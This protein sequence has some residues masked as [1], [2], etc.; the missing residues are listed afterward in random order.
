MAWLRL[1]VGWTGLLGLGVL[2]LP[3]LFALVVRFRRAR[4]RPQSPPGDRRPRLV[5]LVPAHNEELLIR[6][7]VRSLLDQDYPADRRRVVVIADNCSDETAAIARAAGAEVLERTDLEFRGKPRA[8]AWAIDQ[9]GLDGAD[10]FI[11]IDADSEVAADYA[12]R[13]A[14]VGD[15][16]QGAIQTYFGISN[17]Y[18][19]W[20]TRLAGVL[21][22][23]RYESQFPAKRRA[24]LNVPLT[25]NGMVLGA[26]LLRRRPWSAFSVTEDWELYAEYTA[27]GVRV[28]YLREARLISQEARSTDQ[29]ASQ[30]QRW[31]AGR[32]EVWR[33]WGRAIRTSTHISRFQKLDTLLE[34][35]MPS[36][37]LHIALVAMCG[38]AA[39]L[40]G[41][42]PGLYLLGASLAGG[43]L[44][45]GV[46][47][48]ILRH[49]EPLATVR[50]LA[51][52]PGYALWR[53]GVGIGA[54]LSRRAR[55]EW[56]R[57][58]RHE[59]R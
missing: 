5:F 47:A 18:E 50:A 59:H 30:R 25:G 17:E 45:V 3:G 21:M 49:P 7:C 15:L 48:T 1:L 33:E 14:E 12:K 37:A 41:M 55:S 32:R 10:A 28:D 54:R 51:R 46:V 26:E 27:H 56:V 11:V 20:L 39:A 13:V 9:L 36:P 22:R 23:L 42:P 24:G 57:T 44:T 16:R 53:L 43:E 4:P 40:G 34:L 29:S 31:Q 52:A 8:L 2:A 6:P 35:N 38:G 19:T 58:A